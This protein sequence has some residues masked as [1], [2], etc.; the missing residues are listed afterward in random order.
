M[1]GLIDVGGGMR[2]VYTAGIYDY[3]LDNEIEI[4]Y[5]IGISAGSANLISYIS[6][7][8]KRSLKFYSE[9]AMRRQY[10]SAYN[11]IKNG[12]YIDLDYVYSVLSNS[13]G[14]SPV[15]YN[16]FASSKIELEV[17]ATRADSGPAHYFNKDDIKF[18]NFDIIKASCAVP[19]ACKPFNINGELYFD[20]GIADPIPYNRLLNRGCDKLILLLTRPKEVRLKPQKR[21][22]INNTLMHKYPNVSLAMSERH[23]KYNEGIEAV[24]EL[25][26]DNRALIV[27]PCSIFGMKMLKKDKRAINRLYREG[28]SDAKKIAEFLRR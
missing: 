1:V 23:K 15:D 5:C 28:Y 21:E 8:N 12:S 11:F 14:E 7:Q 20:G 6:K 16:T 17:V 13:N 18:D 4:D 25:E 19:I 10:M 27:A 9:Y 22:M 2:G 24:S 26:K 3:L